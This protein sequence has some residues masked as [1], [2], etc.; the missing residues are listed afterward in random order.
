M[1][2]PIDQPENQP[3]QRLFGSMPFLDHLEELR[4]RLLKA[5]GAVIL[6]AMAAL[7][8]A[9]PIMRWFVAPLGN[10]KLH[11]TEVTGSFTAY[12]KVALITGLIAAL[13]IVFYQ[14]WAF[15]S[16]GLYQKERKLTLA[17]VGSATV[18]FVAGALFC[19]Y[20]VLPWSLQFMIGFS[21]DLLS[22]II[23][24]NSYLTFTGMLMLGFGA[25]FELPI[26]AYILGRFGVISSSTL[27]KG[28]RFAV[29]IILVVAA[30]LTPTPDVFTQLLLAVPLYV[31]Y[32]ISIITVRITGKKG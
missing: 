12:L 25:G 26:V 30:F 10:I 13:P 31:L 17:V 24:V 7:Y 9:D 28:R 27:A 20:V 3:E 18:L 22:P 14:L 23:T 8:F 1:S 21:G 4:K 5:F 32:E 15:V 2:K 11:V 29:V 19:Y 6:T 16:P